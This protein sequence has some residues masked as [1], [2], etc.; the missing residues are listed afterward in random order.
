VPA[1]LGDASPIRHVHYVVKENRTYDQVFG[2]LPEGNGAPQLCLF[3]EAVTPNHHALA[4]E[5]VLLDN[6]YA[7]GEVSA[8]GHEW[9][10]GA[11]ASDFVEKTWPLVYGH[12]QHE[13]I[14]Y[15]SEGAYAIAIPERGYLWD[16]AAA[17]GVSYRSYGEFVFNGRTP[18]DPARPSRPVLREHI[19]PQYRAFDLD[20]P[21]VQRAARFISE[22]KRFEAIG[23]M[24]RLQVLRLGNDHTSGTAAGSLTPRALVAD[25]DLALG[26][27]VDAVSHSRFWADC[28][29]IVLE[30]DAQAGPDHI[31]AHRMPC[32]LISPY[33]V[34]HAVDSTLY[35]TTSALRT[36]E[37]I[38]GLQPMSQ[39]DA[40]AT[41]LYAA[42][43]SVPDLTP[44]TA[45][46]ARIDLTERNTADAW[47]A[48]K[49]ARMD[50]READRADDIV[51]N[52]II[53]RSVKGANSPMPAPVRAAFFKAHP[54]TDRDDD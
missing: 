20:Y 2:D 33:T 17:A 45:R 22:L 49:S 44:Y 19:D 29:I 4:R 42:F 41:P 28:A 18:A 53:W 3:P 21:D 43:T 12:S 39:F 46:P 31:D 15:P 38:L 51:L 13:K 9:A 54:K 37:L 10:M 27:I 47:G 48:K 30:D 36:I 1:T 8:D 7:D 24:P 5:F 11:Y 16:Q 23:E 52:E 40:A 26:Q 14:G 32:L 50:F 6:F 35:S 25:N 34:R